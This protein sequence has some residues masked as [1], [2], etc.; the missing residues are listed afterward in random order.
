MPLESLHA[1]VLDPDIQFLIRAKAL[2]LTRARGFRSGDQDD[3]TQELTL[4]QLRRL[5]AYDPAKASFYCFALV[6]LDRSAS[7]LVEARTA[8]C[9]NSSTTLSLQMPDPGVEDDPTPLADLIGPSDRAN[10]VGRY[11]LPEDQ[12]RELVLDVRA[13]LESLPSDLKQL[14]LDLSTA[15]RSEI[16]RRSGESRSRLR[17]RILRLREALEQAGLGPDKSAARE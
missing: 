11:T 6:V 7:S 17:N 9:R 10:R 14:A 3:L 5:K 1:R 16:V 4:R 12:L 2:Q 13:D 8:A 15:K